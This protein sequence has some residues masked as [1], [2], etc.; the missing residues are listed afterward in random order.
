MGELVSRDAGVEHACGEG[1]RIV[2]S[3]FVGVSV[4][5]IYGGRDEELTYVN[6]VVMLKMWG[7]VLVVVDAVVG[8]CCGQTFLAMR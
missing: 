3:L 1:L 5:G 4:G 7:V 6:R 2:P 8:P